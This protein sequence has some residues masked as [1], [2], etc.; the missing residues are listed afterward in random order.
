MHRALLWSVSPVPHAHARLMG[1]PL[2]TP[3][4]RQ[5]CGPCLHS[6]ML[7]SMGCSASRWLYL[8]P[9]IFTPYPYCFTKE[10]DAFCQETL[11]SLSP[12]LYARPRP[13]LP[14]RDSTHCSSSVCLDQSGPIRRQKPGQLLEQRGFNRKD[15]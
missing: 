4:Q 6:A 14:G 9:R 12:A 8:P 10:I 5:R 2:F 1:T 13:A 7:M 15:D 11:L 3:A